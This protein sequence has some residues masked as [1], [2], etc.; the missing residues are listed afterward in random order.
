[1][2]NQTNIVKEISILYELSLAIGCSLDLEENSKIFLERLMSR[3]ALAFA[4]VWIDK[5]QLHFEEQIG[6]N[7]ELAYGT[8]KVR[9]SENPLNNSYKYISERLIKES[10]FSVRDSEADF[11]EVIQEKNIEK[12]VYALFRLGNI[13]FLKLY[14]TKSTTFSKVEMFQL[15]NVL[16]KFTISL[17]ACISH[18][19][20]K[21]EIENRLRVEKELAQSEEKYRLVVQ[22]L[23]EGLMVTDLEN[24]ITFVNEAICRLSGYSKTELLGEIA[25]KKFLPEAEWKSIEEKM[26]ERKAGNSSNYEKR[27][28]KKDGSAWWG[29]ING[30]PLLDTTGEIVG[31]LAAITDITDRKLAEEKRELLLKELEETNKELDDFAYIVSHDL[32]A[33][34]RAIGSLSDWIYTDYAHLLDEDG[35]EQM[36]LLRGR[37]RR[38]HNFIDAILS[39]SRIGRTQLKVEKFDLQLLVERIIDLFEP[40][41][42]TKIIIPDKLPIISGEKVRIGQVFQNLIS[43]GLKYNDKT[44]KVIKISYKEN[45]AFYIFEIEDN[46]MGIKTK[47]FEKIFQIFQTLEARDNFESTGIG[48][49][50]VKK[51]VENHRGEI[52]IESTPNVGSKF[53][54]TLPK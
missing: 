43:N 23:S 2:N 33:P 11:K 10:M 45:K 44:N 54:F 42:N 46:G 32:K 4:G 41:H 3:K 50:V 35:R 38:L 15:R 27:H 26:M 40:L 49:T 6:R 52:N 29:A 30:S 31:S 47:Y 14:S 25:Y 13:G 48:L 34:L 1:M 24:K 21:S 20:L 37:V 9:I 28:I 53:I 5:N 18:V 19:S 16:Q 8:P 39:Y 17:E 51:I 36:N 12:G 22:S 7:C